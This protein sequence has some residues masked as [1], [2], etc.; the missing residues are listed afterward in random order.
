[1]ESKQEFQH[2]KRICLW[3]IAQPDS[4]T[5]QQQLKKSNVLLKALVVVVLRGF[6]PQLL[7]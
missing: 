1:V 3:L 4:N 2:E 7:I 5:P 6:F